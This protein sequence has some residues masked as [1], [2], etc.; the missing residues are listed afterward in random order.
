MYR[1]S[2]ART[3]AR[4][5]VT[6]EAHGVVLQLHTNGVPKEHAHWHYDIRRGRL[7]VYGGTLRAIDAA[8]DAGR[9]ELARQIVS[10]L[11]WY[12]TESIDPPNGAVLRAA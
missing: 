7:C 8:I 11:D 1:T 12:V 9:P 4:K 6:R 2:L 10:W 3:T 5:T